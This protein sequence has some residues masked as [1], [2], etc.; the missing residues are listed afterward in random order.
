[1]FK[2]YRTFILKDSADS[3]NGSEMIHEA[4]SSSLT[5]HQEPDG[6]DDSS[7]SACAASPE[8]QA[9]AKRKW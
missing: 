6:V 2:I 7:A 5:A 9:K 4:S 3:Q 1:M 8:D